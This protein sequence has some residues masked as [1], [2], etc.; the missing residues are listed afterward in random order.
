MLPTRMNERRRIF[1]PVLATLL[2]AGFMVSTRAQE[3]SVP[4]PGLN[5]A[6]RDALQKPSGPLTEQDLFSLT[7]LNASGR[8]I[9]SVE[10]LEAARNLV[11]LD[12]NS[13]SLTNFAI[14]S[15]LTNL[16]TLNLFNNRLTNF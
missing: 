16:T 12:L 7:N 8:N 11:G 2:L 10:G 13:N 3:V 6:I 9:S 14:A 5:A 4:D 15:A 1:L